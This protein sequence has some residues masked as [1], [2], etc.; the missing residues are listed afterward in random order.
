MVL[1]TVLGG[2]SEKEE[3]CPFVL[4]EFPDREGGSTCNAN[5]DPIRRQRAVFQQ[6]S[7]QAVLS[8]AGVFTG[9]KKKVYKQANLK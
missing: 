4:T 8:Q 3:N 1:W 6:I 2:E 9:K 7:S 5:C